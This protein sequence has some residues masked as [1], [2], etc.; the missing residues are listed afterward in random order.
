MGRYCF[1]VAVVGGSLGMVAGALLM[2]TLRTDHDSVVL[3]G[4][5]VAGMIGLVGGSGVL[6]GCAAVARRS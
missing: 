3:A 2:A 4:R 5:L 6:L 1:I